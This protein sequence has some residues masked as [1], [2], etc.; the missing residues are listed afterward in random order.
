MNA[1]W[2]YPDLST[3]RLPL[4][5]SVTQRHAIWWRA[6]LAFAAVMGV[7]A[8]LSLFDER[9]FN[10]VSVWSKPF[11]FALS[12]AVYF[13]TL[14]WFAPLLPNGYL[15]A[16]KGRWLTAV[17]I[18]CAV[19]EMAY[20][21]LQASRGQ[22]SHFN[23]TNLL[24]S[25]L[26]SLMGAG[27]VAMVSICLWMG[28]VILRN[29]GSASPYAFAVGLGLIV[30]FL[31]GGGFGGYMG[32]HLSHWVGGTQSDANGLWPMH[33]SRDGGD[34]RVAHFFGMHAM[35]VLP[36]IGALL[37]RARSHRWAIAGVV[38]AACIYAAG[39]IF[40]FVQALHGAPFI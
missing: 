3:R 9:T 28:I 21:A 13:T 23:N 17:P 26:Y 6:A 27:A 40:T 31:L 19:F 22:A 2:L 20:I 7:C 35:Q 10:G 15:Q 11:K 32:S 33:W 39:T 5:A 1:E 12:I 37:T 38:A 8:L 25:A 34:L 14:A 18:W 24:Y 29:R 30:T 36:V 16:R 4:F